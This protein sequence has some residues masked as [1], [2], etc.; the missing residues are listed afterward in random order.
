VVAVGEPGHGLAELLH[1][2]VQLGP[3]A[4]LFD[5]PIQRS[6]QRLVSGSPSNAGSSPIP[7]HANEPVN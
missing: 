2:V 5:V 1:G 6:A 7:S 4:L 3:Q